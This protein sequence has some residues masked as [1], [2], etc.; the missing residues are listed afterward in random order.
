[1]SLASLRHRFA[2]HKRLGI[3]LGV[4]AAIF[5]LF[6]LLAYFWLPG[7]AKAKL[8]MAL[9]EALHRPVTVQSV[10]IQPYT[11]ELA[12]HGVRVG[13][14]PRS[15]DADKALLS[16]D[17]LYVNLSIASIARRAP[18]ISSVSIRAPAVRLVREGEKRFNISDLI[19]DFLK[20]PKDETRTLF[21]VSNVV[22]EGG[23]FE[24]VDRLK[25]SQQEISDIRIGIP[26]V[27][28]LESSEETWV[29]P[30]FSAVV[31]GA[32]I[33]IEGQALPFAQNR[34][35]KFEL[36]L[37]GID[38]TR[39]DEYSPIPV[40][41]KLVSG[42]F[43]AKLLLTF[44]QIPGEPANLVL[45]G[46]TALRKL[47]VENQATDVP[48][49]A[50]LGQLDVELT[51]INLNSAKPSQGGLI[52]TE[53]VVSR[54]G[55]P[56]PALRL[57]QLRVTDIAVDS[58]RQSLAIG[59]VILERFNASARREPDGRLDLAKFFSAAR[60]EEPALQAA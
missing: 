37:N 15:I 57:P 42:F 21:S 45:T 53:A 12:L 10:E 46:H 24:F 50:K 31:N 52:L 5:L 36:E 6:G 18:V 19:E 26:F 43:D 14:K 27:A 17:K 32:P 2:A 9:S 41:I 49:T 55:D 16:V 54:S 59:S 35:A 44:T 8:E 22:I 23:R 1:M 34:Q 33:L 47:E 13:E 48:Y 40:G 60:K 51:E 11:L 20:R 58:R 30:H 56:A 4:F 25:K 29:E 39:V 7:Y 28:N 3:G 38:L